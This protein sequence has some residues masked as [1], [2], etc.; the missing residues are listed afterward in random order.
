MRNSDFMRLFARLLGAV[1]LMAAAPAFPQA[2]PQAQAQDQ[3]PLFPAEQEWL[4]E[5]NAERKALG[6]EPLRWNHALRR[7][8]QAWA[9]ELAA[10]GAFRH[11]PDL[12]AIGQGENLWKGTRDTYAPWQ[13]ID[14]FLAEKRIF[15]PGVFPEV[16]TTGRWSDVGHYTQIIWPETR[17]VGCA[18]A[19]NRRHEVLVCRY[20]PAGNVMGYRLDPGRHLSRR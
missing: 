20:W 1:L 6:L 2:R 12:L 13:M 4:G 17:E 14:L 8:A 7:D 18:T 19:V 11:S 3:R 5:H 15:R 16:S 10:R 9:E